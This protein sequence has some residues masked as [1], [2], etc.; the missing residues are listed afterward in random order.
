MLQALIGMG[1]LMSEFRKW[2]TE[3]GFK[4]DPQVNGKYQRF[5]H[6]GKQNGWFIGT[7]HR[8]VLGEDIIFATVGD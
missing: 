8:N 1:A 3:L 7:S 2:L 4:F 5:D 6:D